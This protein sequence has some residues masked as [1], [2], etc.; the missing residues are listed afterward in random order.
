MTRETL[1][2]GLVLVVLVGCSPTPEAPMARPDLSIVAA[3]CEA[4]PLACGGCF[5]DS[6]C[7]DPTLSRC[8]VV[9]RRC[10]RCLPA[11]DNCPSGSVCTQQNGEWLCTAS[12]ASNADCQKVGGGSLC[13]GGACVN[14]ATDVRNCG[15]CGQTCP[16]VPNG[17]AG[18]SDG[19]CVVAGCNGGFEDCDLAPINGCEVQ[20]TSDPAHCGR[21]DMACLP[22]ANGLPVCTAGMCS[23]ICAPGHADCDNDT[24]N[25]CEI[26]VTGDAANCGACGKACAAPPNAIAACDL[27]ACGYRCKLG[28]ADCDRDAGNGCE[29]DTSSSTSDCGRCGNVCPLRPNAQGALCVAGQCANDCAP[30]FADCDRRPANGCE[31]DSGTDLANCGGCGKLCSNRNAIATCAMGTCTLQ[32]NAGFVDCNNDTTD[33]CE[34]DLRSDPL[35]CGGC[36]NICPQNLPGCQ[37][38]QCVQGY[39][40]MGP[41]TN[42]PVNMLAGWQQCY[43]GT[44]NKAGVSIAQ[45]LAMCSGSKLLLACRPTGNPTL[46][47]MAW[48]NRPDVLFDVG[49]VSNAFHDA[50]GTSW[51]FANTYSWGFFWPGDGVS[52]NSCDTAS[53]AHREARLCWH[54]SAG[55]IN[56]GYRCGASTGL[57]ASALWE[58]LV[59]HMP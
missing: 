51:Y 9:T 4:D 23:A 14:A 27:G 31:S 1:C 25:G 58:R 36:G 52:R 6:D 24:A 7:N 13:C 8:D 20:V 43:V 28:F 12:C 34:A 30:G 3:D 57:N 47:L 56:G 11:A 21:C 39:F 2:T 50:N 16:A 48:A 53:G 29:V 10:V 26:D 55:N 33:G 35:N 38:G 49:N 22:F 42:I 41:Q 54:T 40:P 5:A 45:L 15:A 37:N 46:T 44:Y 17:V 18:C 59:Y 32:C 19:T